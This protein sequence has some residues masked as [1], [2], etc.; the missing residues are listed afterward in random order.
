MSVKVV[1][2]YDH[3]PYTLEHHAPEEIKAAVKSG[4][5]L[6]LSEVDCREYEWTEVKNVSHLC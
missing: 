2:G 6:H 1:L 3:P 4:F 5:A